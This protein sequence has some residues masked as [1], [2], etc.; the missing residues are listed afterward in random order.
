MQLAN[1]CLNCA[2]RTSVLQ[3]YGQ[4]PPESKSRNGTLLLLTIVCFPEGTMI[5]RNRVRQEVVQ[6]Y[7]SHANCTVE[8]ESILVYP[9]EILPETSPRMN[10][11][12][13]TH[14]LMCNL[15]DKTAC[16]TVINNNLPALVTK[17]LL[18][19]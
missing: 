5:T 18:E 13:C 9:A 7:C 2:K 14:Y 17:S 3:E 6:K 19:Q 12:T 1:L 8:I 11:R 4:M 10:Q 15:Q 16:T